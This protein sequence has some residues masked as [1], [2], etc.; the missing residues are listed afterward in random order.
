MAELKSILSHLKA[1]K[2][3]LEKEYFVVEIGVFGSYARQEET[4]ESDID[5][6]IQFREGMDLF[7]LAQLIQRLEETF[8]KKVDIANKKMLRPRIGKRILSEVIYV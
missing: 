1:L 5:I 2:P 3:M 7:K 6:L 4:P 8:G